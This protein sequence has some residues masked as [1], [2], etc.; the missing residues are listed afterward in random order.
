MS[1]ANWAAQ[2]PW[3]HTIGDLV[4]AVDAEHRRAVRDV[5]AAAGQLV[6]LLDGDGQ[7]LAD[8]DDRRRVGP[9]R[10]MNAGSKW[11]R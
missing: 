2:V 4:V 1:E 6:A 10:P 3:V 9:V 7:R 8:V 5:V 11:S